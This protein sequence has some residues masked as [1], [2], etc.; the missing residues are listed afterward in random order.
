[1]VRM[2]IT[3]STEFIFIPKSTEQPIKMSLPVW[4]KQ[5]TWSQSPKPSYYQGQL[6]NFE[7]KRQK[8]LIVIIRK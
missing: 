7:K 4:T 2:F 3:K 6:Q 1:M 8:M 5:P